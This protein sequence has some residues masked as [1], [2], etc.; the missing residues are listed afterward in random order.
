MP[1]DLD[2][3][4]DPWDD[5]VQRLR[6]RR[7]R[8]EPEHPA[9]LLDGRDALLHVVRV[10]LVR[11]VPQRLVPLDLAP[12]QLGQLQH[13]RRLGRREVEVLVDGRGRLD[14]QADA[15]RQVAA[16]GVVADLPAVAQDMQRILALEHL[17]DQVGHDVAHGQP[18]V[19]RHDLLVG[20]GPLLADADAVERPDDGVGQ[21]VLLVGALGEVL[22]R[23]L[24]EA[25]GRLRRRAAALLPLGGRIDVGA[26]VDH[27]RRD[28]GDPLEPG[29]PVRPDGR[30]EG[31]G[32]DPLVL[33]EQ[34]VGQLVEER[35]PADDRRAGDELV[36]VGQQLLQQ[37]DVLGVAGDAAVARVGVVAALDGPVLG[38]I[39]EADDLVSRR[40]EFLDQIARDE[41]GRAGDEDLHDG[42]TPLPK[43]FQ[44]SMTGLE[45]GS[46]SRRYSRCGA[47]T[48]SSSERATTSSSGRKQGSWM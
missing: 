47:P 20:Q 32:G 38:V 18:D 30:V 16:V 15:A 10:R 42:N 3:P 6:Q 1:S 44:M 26:L 13:R 4:A 28:D 41:S 31:G 5:L 19:A 17:L 25:V 39:V 9:C 24:L 7:R 29:L 11:D 46:A 40:Q 8:L 2:L 14:G 21:A 12:D 35:D 43:T 34:V 48:N 36:A 33:G 27:R 22:R 45:S 23:Q 37:A